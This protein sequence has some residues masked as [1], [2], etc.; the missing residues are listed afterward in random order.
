LAPELLDSNLG[1]G[2]T[3]RKGPIM[4]EPREM[5]RTN[6]MAI[7]IT[8]VVGLGLLFGWFFFPNW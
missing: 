6:F 3:T 8:L 7:I 5:S 2:T 1:T 4:P